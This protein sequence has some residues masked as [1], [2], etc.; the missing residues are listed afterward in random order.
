MWKTFKCIP[1]VPI[2]F[3]NHSPQSSQCVPREFPT[4]SQRVPNVFPK[5]SHCD[6]K[7]SPQALFNVHYVSA[8]ALA[9]FRGGDICLVLVYKATSPVLF[10]PPVSSSAHV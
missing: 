6:Q 8:R 5:R 10:G 9:T 7:A 4:R 3:P 1:S 2:E